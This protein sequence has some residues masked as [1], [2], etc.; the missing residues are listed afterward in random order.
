V[1]LVMVLYIHCPKAHMF[2][3]ELT[4]PL[5]QLQLLVD[6]DLGL[7]SPEDLLAGSI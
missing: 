2:R 4:V 6:Q 7:V 1:E 5:D 3:G